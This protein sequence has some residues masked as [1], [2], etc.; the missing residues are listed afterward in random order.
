MDYVTGVQLSEMVEARGDNN[1]E[2]ISA[3]INKI[4]I[5]LMALLCLYYL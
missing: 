1:F 3:L 5:Y 2:V 4:E